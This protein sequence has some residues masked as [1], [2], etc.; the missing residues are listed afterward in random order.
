MGAISY[1]CRSY[2]GK[3]D[4]GPHPEYGFY[5]VFRFYEYQFDIINKIDEKEIGFALIKVAFIVNEPWYWWFLM[6]FMFLSR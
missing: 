2:R 5:R 6:S 4:R 1:V 3:T